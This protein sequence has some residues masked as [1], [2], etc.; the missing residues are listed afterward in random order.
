VA[1]V[2]GNKDAVII[3]QKF[4][5]QLV[6]IADFFTVCEE[7]PDGVSPDHVTRV[8]LVQ[9]EITFSSVK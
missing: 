4:H 1:G 3:A 7:T 2:G 9:D 6:S 8:A 5:A